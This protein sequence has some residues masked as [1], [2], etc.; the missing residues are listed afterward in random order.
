MM[1][2][3]IE[4][5][6]SV[7]HALHYTSYSTTAKMTYTG[8]KHTSAATTTAKMWC[9]LHYILWWSTVKSAAFVMIRAC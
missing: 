1:Y 9:A 4:L 2:T 6:H 3:R 7:M 8:V 5:T